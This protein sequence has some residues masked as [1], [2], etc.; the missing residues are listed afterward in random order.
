MG[1][2][3]SRSCAPPAELDVP[4][5]TG[6]VPISGIL[7]ASNRTHSSYSFY[8]ER[9]LLKKFRQFAQSLRESQSQAWRLCSQGL[10][11]GYA[12]TAQVGP[13]CACQSPVLGRG[14][15]PGLRSRLDSTASRLARVLSGPHLCPGHPQ[16]DLHRG[17]GALR[18]SRRESKASVW[19]PPRMAAP[20]GTKIPQT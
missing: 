19:L 14:S 4:N 6:S 2:V 11:T 13:H 17:E 18:P 3:H 5:T 9:N 1:E 7:A 8:Y 20:Q 12:T 10:S 16:W 15:V